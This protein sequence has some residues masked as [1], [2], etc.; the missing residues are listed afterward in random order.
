M[1]RPLSAF[2]VSALLVTGGTQVVARS[3]SLANGGAL[4]GRI[5]AASGGD[6]VKPGRLRRER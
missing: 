1:N 5:G 4:R 3:L 6:I 2:I